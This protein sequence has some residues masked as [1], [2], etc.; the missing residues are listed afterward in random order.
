MRR[1]GLGV[2]ATQERRWR[3][4]YTYTCTCKPQCY[5]TKV[6]GRHAHSVGA[7]LEVGEEKVAVAELA[8]ILARRYKV[9]GVADITVWQETAEE[10]DRR[11]ARAEREA[12]MERRGIHWA[13]GG[14][15]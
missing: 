7:F 2:T 3:V 12:A 9:E 4:S 11:V 10:R 5:W 15:N 13:M 8:P 6:R 1:K 14:A